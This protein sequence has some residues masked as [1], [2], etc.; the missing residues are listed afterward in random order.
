[1]VRF[2]ADQS[3]EREGGRLIARAAKIF[4]PSTTWPVRSPM[5][6]RGQ[7]LVQQILLVGAEDGLHL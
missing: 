4:L 2:P 1:M 5:A 6:M 7:D 3:L